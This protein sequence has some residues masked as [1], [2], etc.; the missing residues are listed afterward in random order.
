MALTLV[1]THA[2]LYASEF[3]ADRSEVIERAR[4]AGISTILLPNIDLDSVEPML[5]LVA[6]EPNGFRPM[7]GL[8]PCYVSDED[9]FA[10]LAEIATHWDR[11]D[12]VA[13][14][15]I[16]IDLHW[17]TDNLPA[18]QTVFRTQLNWAVERNLP[19]AIH[20]RESNDQ[21][22]EV[23]EDMAQPGLCGVQHCFTG[24]LAE[25]QR[26]LDLG[27]YLGI[28]GVSTFKKGGLDEVLPHIGLDRLILETDCPYLAPTPNRGKRNEP[29]YLTYIVARLSELLGISPEHIIDQTTQNAT[30]LFGLE[31]KT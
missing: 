26:L 7:L 1:D 29:A 2:H 16:G 5:A 19:V 8:H 22:A 31:N 23:L 11:A 12:Y 9:P 18:Q 13:V 3:D 25:A 24:T 20:A 21:V 15:E 6:S 28:G 27:F 4:L 14:G 10:Q 17:R 30:A